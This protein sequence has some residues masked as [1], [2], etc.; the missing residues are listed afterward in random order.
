[1]KACATQ[2][3]SMKTSLPIIIIRWR[4]MEISESQIRSMPHDES[5]NRNRKVSIT[6]SK[7][8]L[9]EI[10]SVDEKLI[11]PTPLGVIHRFFAFSRAKNSRRR[12]LHLPLYA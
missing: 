10:N 7:K 1:M 12:I 3:A 6:T 8:R 11:P 4:K 5:G 2:F 9:T